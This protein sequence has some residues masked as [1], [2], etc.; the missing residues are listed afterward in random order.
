MSSFATEQLQLGGVAVWWPVAAGYL[1]RVTVY[2]D[3]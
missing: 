2:F 1:G 3:P